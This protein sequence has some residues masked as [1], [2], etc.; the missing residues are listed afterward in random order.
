[1]RV[2]SFLGLKG[3]T[4]KT[5]ISHLLAHGCGLNGVKSILAITDAQR[6]PLETDGRKYE[7]YDAR[8][9]HDIFN[10]INVAN[11]YPDDMVLIIDGCRNRNMDEWIHGFSDLV[12]LPFMDGYDDIQVISQDLS[13][14][15]K[16]V[17]IP[18]HWP[19]NNLALK[20]TEK[21]VKPL[22]DEFVNRIF[23]PLPKAHAMIEITRLHFTGLQHNITD[24]ARLFAIRTLTNMGF[25]LDDKTG[26]LVYAKQSQK[27]SI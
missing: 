24:I 7:I 20:A 6:L 19:T 18:N 12:I 27:A 8:S 23:L 15:P 21:V 11:N 26:K 2:I 3:G 16:A 25:N 22:R 1:M 10:L 14:L 5:T 9:A 17:A 4:G 13:R